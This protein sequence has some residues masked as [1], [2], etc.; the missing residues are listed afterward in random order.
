MQALQ[1]LTERSRTVVLRAW[2]RL[3]NAAVGQNNRSKL[4]ILTPMRELKNSV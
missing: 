1:F 4:P 3:R 2:L